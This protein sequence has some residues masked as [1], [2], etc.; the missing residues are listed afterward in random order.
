M[1]MRRHITYIAATALILCVF[2]GC[3]KF[4]RLY[5]GNNIV[6]ESVE[7]TPEDF[8]QEVRG[9]YAKLKSKMT[10][11]QSSLS[12]R[13]DEC[14]QVAMAT[15][16]QNQYDFDHFVENSSSAIFS[17]IWSNW[18]N[19]IFR[20][21]DLLSHIDGQTFA[22]A[23][24]YEAEA[25]FIRSWFYFNLYRCFG[26][27]PLTTVAVSPEEA[28]LVP[29]CTKEDMLDR[30]ETD[31]KKCIE[32]LPLARSEEVARVTKIAAQALLGKVYLTFGK[33]PEAEAVLADA[34]EDPWYGLMPT[35]AD[36]FDIKNKMNKEVIFAL[37]YNK[38]N[39]NGHSFWWDSTSASEDRTN[40]TQNLR[41]LYDEKKDNRYQLIGSWKELE[42]SDAFSDE[43]N[44]H[45]LLKWYDNYDQTFIEQVGND[46]PHLR[47]ADV[48]LMMAEA[49]AQQNKVAEAH[50][51][52]NMTRTR[53]GLAQL[54]SADISAKEDFIKELAA[55]RGREFA[56]EGQ[57]WFDLVRLGL[58]VEHFR[59]LH[60]EHKGQVIDYSNIS[61]KNLVFPIPNAQI[62][63]VGNKEIL[64]QNPGFE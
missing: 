6:K 11:H 48:V 60:V 3:E 44:R 41:D 57:R 20:C 59:N 52:M 53:A 27:V 45:V 42:V 14:I 43:K 12:Y 5:P 16:N 25:L 28:V 19:G 31:L 13:S 18:Y 9:C 61:E 54:S 15:S 2:T 10:F 39:G 30:L 34:L 7:W 56:L 32:N 63:I 17:D 51:Y 47:Y 58:A 37:Y 38:T 8:N 26:G 4:F 55:E 50:T 64:W 21:N 33:Y 22:K 40:P 1:Q 29:R 62:E 49:L 24:Q 35:T 23:S 46:F 36:V